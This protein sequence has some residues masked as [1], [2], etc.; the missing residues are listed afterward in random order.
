M[1]ALPALALWCSPAKLGTRHASHLVLTGKSLSGASSWRA[2]GGGCAA[3]AV[4]APAGEARGRPVGAR[5]QTRY[6]EAGQAGR[7][8]VLQRDAGVEPLYVYTY[9]IILCPYA[10]IYNLCVHMY[11]D[12]FRA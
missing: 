4:G 6:E 9:T 10:H 2:G 8:S 12:C 7:Q 1:V 11:L 3:E 5:A